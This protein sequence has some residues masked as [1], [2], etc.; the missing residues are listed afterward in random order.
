MMSFDIDLNQ[1]TVKYGNFEALKK[2]SLH[3]ETDKI[4]GLIGR[5]GAGKST[6]LSLLASFIGPTEGTVKIGG[7][8]PFEN[9][10]VMQHVT[11]VYE[12]NYSDESE[13]VKGMLEAAERYRPNF[14]RE[15]AEE[16]VKLFNLPLDKQV[17]QLSSGMQSVLNVTIGL[18]NRALIT[19]F[20]EAYLGMDAPTREIFYKEVLEDQARHPRTMILSTHLVSEMDYLFEDVIMIHK[21]NLLLKEPIDQLIERGASITG[22]AKDVEEFVRDMKQLSTQQLGGT[23]SIIVY[24]E[25]TE[26]KL[27]EAGQIGLEVG[28]VSLQELFIHLTSEEV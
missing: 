20:D 1:V 27:N 12:T 11:L 15:Y 26:A 24:G 6:L 3:L 10:E 25:M 13:N 7:K 22:A 23:K 28:P 21:G 4:Y 9:E 5:N 19:I 2:F 8:E 16:L 14:N 18:A 17:K